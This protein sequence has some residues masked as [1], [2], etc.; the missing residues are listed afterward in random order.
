MS[1]VGR[2]LQRC[3]NALIAWCPGCKYAHPF[4]LS[5]WRFD[6]NTE[7]PTFSPSLLCNAG[8]SNDKHRCHAFVRNGKWE[9]QQDCFHELRG[10]TVPMVPINEDWEPES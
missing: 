4:D 10:Q 8:I 6:G 7:A 3:D 1:A 5:R 2:F 9:F